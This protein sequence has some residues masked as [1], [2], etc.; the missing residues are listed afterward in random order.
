MAC[1]FTAWWNCG[2]KYICIF[3]RCFQTENRIWDEELWNNLHKFNYSLMQ[4]VSTKLGL[5]LQIKHI[6]SACISTASAHIYGRSHMYNAYRSCMYDDTR[7]SDLL[8]SN[9]LT[10]LM[11][12]CCF[13]SCCK[14]HCAVHETK[15]I[16]VATVNPQRDG[17]LSLFNPL[18]ILTKYLFKIT[19]NILNLA[20]VV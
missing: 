13:G 5:L 1:T 9:W 18:H 11:N 3:I 12:S 19:I 7:S 4:C 6:A 2:G 15:R 16:L 14:I 17:I 20:S 10:D 8:R